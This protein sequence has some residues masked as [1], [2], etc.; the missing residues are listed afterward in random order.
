[1]SAM[2]ASLWIIEIVARTVPMVLL[3]ERISRPLI[4]QTWRDLSEGGILKGDLAYK[5]SNNL[6]MNSSLA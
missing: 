3:G 2:Q 4:E 6:Q 5:V 1:M